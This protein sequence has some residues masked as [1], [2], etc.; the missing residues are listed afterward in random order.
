MWYALSVNMELSLARKCD[1]ALSLA[2]SYLT[3]PETPSYEARCSAV[4][5]LAEARARLRVQIEEQQDT[6]PLEPVHMRPMPRQGQC[7]TPDSIER[8]ARFMAEGY[9]AR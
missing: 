9:R 8:L 3:A 1:Q 6:L 4:E 2:L 5:A 7:M